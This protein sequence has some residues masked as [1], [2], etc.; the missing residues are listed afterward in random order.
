MRR[1][2]KKTVVFIFL[3]SFLY[4]SAAKASALMGASLITLGAII[5]MTI[6]T[7]LA[8]EM[9]SLQQGIFADP[10]PSKT[11]K[12]SPDGT[13]G[14]PV[15]VQ[16]IDT[17]DIDPS[18]NP[19]IKQ[20]DYTAKLTFDKMKADVLASDTTKSKYPKLATALEDVESLPKLSRRDHPPGYSF[21]MYGV[22]SKTT[23]TPSYIG[24]RSCSASLP[25]Y[26]VGKDKPSPGYVSYFVSDPQPSDACGSDTDAGGVYSVPYAGKP[27][28][29][30]SPV[31]KSKFA[32]R[33]AGLS[34]SSSIS[35]PKDVFSD[36]YADIDRYIQDFP[37]SVSI[38]DGKAWD[39]SNAPVAVL[40][41]PA[42]QKSVDALRSAAD[43]KQSSTL[44]DA[45]SSAA[46]SAARNAVSTAQTN[47]NNNPSAEN[48]QKLADAQSAKSNLESQQAQQ[49]AET[50]QKKADADAEASKEEDQKSAVSGSSFNN[51][52][53]YGDSSKDFDFGNRFKLFFDQ[54]KTTAVFSIPTRF[55]S[56]VPSSNVSSVSFDAGRFG[57]QSFDFSAFY[58]LWES[59][60]AVILVLFGWL[61]VRIAVL[62]GGV[63]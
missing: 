42:T 41:T 35:S 40:P 28:I 52:T 3:I 58:S 1:T 47:Y 38:V 9:I 25:D 2:I 37:G 44:A 14:R 30:T 45:A 24:P 27:D 6:Y 59:F 33:L 63:G 11:S 43:S 46:S 10:D 20:S 19:S 32:S 50:A 15:S 31:T 8:S 12:I 51:G 26:F 17:K 62:K 4:T 49:A 36:Y 61:S 13:L 23:S 7:G 56:S 16:W 57:R 21:T 18:G 48:A 55:L 60:R 22:S 53:P 29:I 34:D 5:S 39:L 54:M